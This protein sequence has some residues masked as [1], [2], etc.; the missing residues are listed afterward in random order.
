LRDKAPAFISAAR[1][2]L[3]KS[4]ILIENHILPAKDLPKMEKRLPEIIAMNPDQ[5]I[6]YYYPRNNEHPEDIMRIMARHLKK[7]V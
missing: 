7:F 1:V 6:Y 5:L 4:V 3:C 2:N